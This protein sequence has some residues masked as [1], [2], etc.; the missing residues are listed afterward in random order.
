MM[1]QLHHL[2]LLLFSIVT[3]SGCCCCAGIEDAR[4]AAREAQSRNN[5]QM[6]VLAALNYETSNGA[7]PE[8]LEDLREFTPD[9][10]NVVTNPVTMDNP[11]YEYV[12]P[13]VDE[14]M[15]LYDTIILY[16]LRNGVRDTS[17][18]VGYADGSVRG[19]D[20]Y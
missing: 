7:W 18:A 2:A 12:K 11:G 5:M 3:F 1:R 9:F 15:V 17:L 16:Q 19:G 8:S 13:V 20:G 10:D 14:D 6:L 4:E